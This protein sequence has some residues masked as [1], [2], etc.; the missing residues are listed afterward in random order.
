MYDYIDKK[1][2]KSTRYTD[3][4]SVAIIEHQAMKIVRKPLSTIL[5][6]I[7]SRIDDG[8]L[9]DTDILYM[10]PTGKEYHTIPTS[11]IK[12]DKFTGVVVLDDGTV[13]RKRGSIKPLLNWMDGYNGRHCRKMYISR[14]I[15]RKMFNE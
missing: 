14:F 7:R 11:R 4:H 1:D 13:I 15:G 6:V 5:S 12:N 2:P 3:C 8:K 10:V 9:L